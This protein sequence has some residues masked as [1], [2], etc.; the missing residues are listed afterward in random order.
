VQEF[1]VNYPFLT[2]SAALGLVVLMILTGNLIP[3]KTHER[4]LNREI[5]R[6]DE[7]KALADKALDAHAELV[8]STRITADAL[9]AIPKAENLGDD[10]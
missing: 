6:G 2:P 9:K 4:E 3:R 10:G 8:E 1:F 5:T 7:F